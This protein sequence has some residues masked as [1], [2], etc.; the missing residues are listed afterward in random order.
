MLLIL[1]SGQCDPN[2]IG[3][4][5]WAPLHEVVAKEDLD[6]AAI[7]LQHGA[8]PHRR[9][10][11]TRDSPLHMAAKYGNTKMLQLLLG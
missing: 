5:G 10:L 3:L 8:V 6:C 9:D 7:L 11:V 4:Y 2:T 1:K